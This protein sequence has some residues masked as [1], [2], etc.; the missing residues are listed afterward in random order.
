VR[1]S[2]IVSQIATVLP[3]LVD[4][5]TDSLTVTSL[6]RSGLVATATTSTPHA[7]T[8]GLQVSINGAQTPIEI[9]SLVRV[10]IMATMTTATDHDLTENAGFNVQ[11]EG[12]SEAE[13]NGSFTLLRVPNRRTIVFQVSDSGATSVTGSPLLINGSNGFATYNGLF[14]VASITTA[15]TFTYSVTN[16]TM[17]TQARGTITA[18]T[19]PRVS[20]AV[21]IERSLDGYTKQNINKA[22]LFVVLGDALASKNRNIDIDATDNIQRGNYFNQRLIQNVGLYVVIPASAEIAGRQARDRCEELL[23]PICQTVLA[24]KFP[25]LVE[26]SNNPLMITSHGL[27]DYNTAYYVHQYNFEATLQL[28][29]SDIYTPDDSVAFRDIGLTQGFDIGPGTISTEIDLDDEPL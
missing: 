18:R 25:S 23:S 28:G 15:T 11:I 7:L 19:N 4:D 10:G 13:F 1:A 22:W 26:N 14:E 27:H 21:T 3:K 17:Y 6:S 20:S 29:E 16:S 5:F 24:A 9:S 8:V 2:D 12:A